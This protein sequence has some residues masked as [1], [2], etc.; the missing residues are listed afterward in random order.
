MQNLH[1]ICQRFYYN[2]PTPKQ[3]SRMK[4][5]PNSQFTFL[6]IS[7]KRKKKIRFHC[8]SLIKVNGEFKR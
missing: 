4:V 6:I 5:D 7:L 3:Y 2:A 1:H 8:V